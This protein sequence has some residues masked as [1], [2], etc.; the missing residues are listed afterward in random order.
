MNYNDV[1]I[2]LG[3]PPSKSRGLRKWFHK[4]KIPLFLVDEFRTSKMCCSC[5]HD[6]LVCFCETYVPQRTED[7]KIIFDEK[8]KVSYYVSIYHIDLE[9]MI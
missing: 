8:G 3:N 2:C 1:L 9:L 6:K 5:H 4:A 7:K